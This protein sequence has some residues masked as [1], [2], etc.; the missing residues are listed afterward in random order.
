MSYKYAIYNLVL[1]LTET[2]EQT[3]RI[4]ADFA[5]HGFSGR[6]TESYYRSTLKFKTDDENRLHGSYRGGTFKGE[7]SDNGSV[8]TGTWTQYGTTGRFKFVMDPSGNR[9]EGP[10][11]NGLGPLPEKSR[12]I[13]SAVRCQ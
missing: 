4:I 12:N 7:L 8:V 9:F 1:E 10:W 5:G 6:W 3:A 2:D 11:C 13:W